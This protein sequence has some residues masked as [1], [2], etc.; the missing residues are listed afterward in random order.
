MRSNADVVEVDAE[1]VELADGT[2]VAGERIV[3]AAGA[4][5]SR[6]FAKR[7]AV[8]PVKGQTVRLRGP[9]PATRIIRSEHVYIVPR[10]NGETVLG[11]T[12]EDV[13]FDDQPTAEATEL[14]LRQAIRAVPVVRELEVVEAVAG[15][16]PGTP[17]DG[18]LIGEWE[19]LVVATG[20]FRNGILLAP[21]TAEAVAALLSGEDPPPEVA[22][23]DPKRFD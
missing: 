18:P 20:H 16:R 5:S 4:W 2:R 13:G 9:V 6:R 17:D 12:V 19:G 21:V 7:L 15:L 14:L 11:A 8:R 23:F 22:P 3:L 10:A 1:H